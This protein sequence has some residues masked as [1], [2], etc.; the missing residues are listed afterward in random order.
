GNVLKLAPGDET[1]PIRTFHL[2]L[3][4]GDEAEEWAQAIRETRFGLVRHERDALR[5]TKM[6]LSDQQLVTHEEAIHESLALLRASRGRE[7]AAVSELSRRDAEEARRVEQ[8]RAL[9]AASTSSP[10]ASCDGGDIADNLADPPEWARSGRERPRSSSS[11][12]CTG[13]GDSESSCLRGCVS[14][15]SLQ[16]QARAEASAVVGGI[17]TGVGGRG[18]ST[19]AT[20][21]SELAAL[22][23]VIAE[24]AQEVASLKMAN[25]ALREK[26]ALA[27]G[28]R[29]RDVAEALQLRDQER[30]RAEGEASLR[31]DLE[32]ELQRLRGWLAD[33]RAGT[34]EARVNLG[35]V[36]AACREAEAKS[37]ELQEHRRVLAR[38]VKASRAEQ[39]RLSAAL[40][41][42]T[43]AAAAAAATA[44]AAKAEASAANA[45]AAA[46]SAAASSGSRDRSSSAASSAAE[47]LGGEVA[48]RGEGEE[49]TGCVGGENGH[50]FE[51][52]S[53]GEALTLPPPEGQLGEEKGAAQAAVEM[54]AETPDGGGSVRSGGDGGSGRAAPGSPEATEETLSDSAMAQTAPVVWVRPSSLDV[55]AVNSR[56]QGGGEESTGGSESGA[57]SPEEGSPVFPGTTDACEGVGDGGVSGGSGEGGSGSRPGDGGFGG[58]P[59]TAGEEGPSRRRDEG[60]F[61]A[62]KSP[63]PPAAGGGVGLGEKGDEELEE[64]T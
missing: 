33:S 49:G 27:D 21:L 41:C 1:S 13:G 63:S 16:E 30:E 61:A 46:A 26:E 38:E 58:G 50:D 45:A 25:E 40:S 6:G 3:K 20:S 4:D 14:W 52:P 37:R 60:R 22:E 48:G 29:R 43:T 2:R 42:A 17:G 51:R 35:V 55:A 8:V 23:E 32:A 59:P 24:R 10:P 31:S 19:A 15:S 11:S 64:E 47:D 44:A 18:S 28:R 36:A 7:S 54:A 57:T 62:S 5:C 53:G 34:E 12:S 9:L 39:Q 56:R